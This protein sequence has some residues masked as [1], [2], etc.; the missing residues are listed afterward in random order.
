[1]RAQTLT[2]KYDQVQDRIVVIVRVPG[3]DYALLLTRRFTCGLLTML[4]RQVQQAQGDARLAQAGLQDE[5]LT[6]KHVRA[7]SQVRGAQVDVSLS[8]SPLPPLPE[9]LPSHLPTRVDAAPDAEGGVLLTFFVA[10]EVLGTLLFRPRDLHWFLERLLAHA[11][12]AGWGEAIPVPEWLSQGA[13]D[14]AAS[15]TPPAMILR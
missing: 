11:K 5:L 4:V 7:V 15:S 2:V 9:R 10:A 6:M 1:M 3:A 13:A 12:A 8:L 14:V